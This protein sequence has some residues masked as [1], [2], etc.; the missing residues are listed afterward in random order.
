MF[1]FLESRRILSAL[2]IT[3]YLILSYILTHRS[4]IRVW[5]ENPICGVVLHKTEILAYC[6]KLPGFSF[7]CALLHLG[8]FMPPNTGFRLGTN[9][10]VPGN[11]K[12]F[13]RL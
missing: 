4:L 10:G 3:L 12:P 7:A 8:N 1:L 11:P 5:T 9:F 13:W 6:G 2:H